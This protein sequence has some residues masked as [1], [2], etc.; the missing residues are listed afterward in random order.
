LRGPERRRRFRA[1]L[2]AGVVGLELD[3]EGEE[4][5]GR[6]GDELWRE[7]GLSPDF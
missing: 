3:L 2:E 6:G 5:E 1:D 4:S 7:L